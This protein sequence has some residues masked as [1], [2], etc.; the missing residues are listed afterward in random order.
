MNELLTSELL[1]F[2]QGLL[3]LDNS[4]AQLLFFPLVLL[5]DSIQ[6][7]PSAAVICTELVMKHLMSCYDIE[8]LMIPCIR[9]MGV[10]SLY[11]GSSFHTYIGINYLYICI[12]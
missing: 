6:Y 3:S 1:P 11:G 8:E 10:C 2:I 9:G 4:P 5:I 12:I 7:I